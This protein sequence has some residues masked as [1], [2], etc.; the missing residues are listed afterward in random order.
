MGKFE[1]E[2]TVVMGILAKGAENITH[3]DKMVLLS[4]Y[5]TPFHD[6]GKIEGIFSCDSSCHHCGF[7]QAIRENNADNLLL[8]CNY[9]YD[10]EQENR[11][12]NVENRHGLQLLIMS[13]V[14]FTVEELSTLGM[15]G[16][17]RFNS[18]GDMQ[19][20]IMA[21]NY[22]RMCFSHQSMSFAL[23]AKHTA[24]VIQATDELGK[25]ENCV[26]IQ[27]SLFIGIRAKLAKYF[28]HTFTVY[29][30]EESLKTA[31]ASGSVE[32]NGKKCKDC[33]Y[34]CY[35]RGWPTGCDIAEYLRLSK[36]A[37]KAGMREKI[38]KALHEKLAKL[39]K[40]F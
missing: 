28:D 40:L 3:E 24:P 21:R 7:C 2:E 22:L 4:I 33:G 37:E 27:S 9:C 35:L 10:D 25:P 18:S 15:Y 34:K 14:D 30:D 8:I 5:Q 39:A 29:P 26:Y 6:S 11:W 13:S 17:C 38:V 31:L 23:W 20:V 36:A 32:C 19:N 12:K 16:I 1:R